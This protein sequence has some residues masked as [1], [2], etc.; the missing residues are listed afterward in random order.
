MLNPQLLTTFATIVGAGTSVP[1]P[2]GWAA[3]SGCLAPTVARLEADSFS[4]PR[5][6]DLDREVGEVVGWRIQPAH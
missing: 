1:Q 4:A 2:C 6:A 3:K 5:E